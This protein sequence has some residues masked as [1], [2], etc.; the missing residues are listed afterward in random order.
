MGWLGVPSGGNKGQLQ[1]GASLGLADN[2]WM[3]G[4]GPLA[5]CFGYLSLGRWPRA[6]EWL[7]HTT[8]RVPFPLRGWVLLSQVSR[9]FCRP[10]KEMSDARPLDF[11]G[12]QDAL[13][14]AVRGRDGLQLQEVQQHL[15]LFQSRREGQTSKRM[16]GLQVANPSWPTHYQDPAGDKSPTMCTQKTRLGPCKS[17]QV[18]RE[19]FLALSVVAGRPLQ[20]TEECWGRFRL[21]V[22]GQGNMDL[23]LSP[24]PGT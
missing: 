9:S 6:W 5:F 18:Q 1:S 2:T 7:N 4:L 20:W 10:L 3:I 11:S 19:P 13:S 22:A 23:S 24:I 8:R 12:K 17:S 14:L 15:D 16:L 21:P